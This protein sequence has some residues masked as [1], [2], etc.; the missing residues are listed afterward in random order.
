MSNEQ[1]IYVGTREAANLLGL[2]PR[3][4]DRYR[5]SGEGPVFY[6]FGKRVCYARTDLEEWAAVRRRTSTADPGKARAGA[7]R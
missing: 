4:L 2:S 1:S 6:K 5:I 7:A 3:T